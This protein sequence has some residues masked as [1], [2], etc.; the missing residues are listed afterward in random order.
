MNRIFSRTAWNDFMEWVKE[1]H[2]IARKVDALLSDIERNSHEGIGK[3]EALRHDF[4]GYWSRRITEKD[5]LIYR[6][7]DDN[8]YIAACKSHCD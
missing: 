5:H 2:K 3:P 4:A 8:I 1:D 6:Y 7:D